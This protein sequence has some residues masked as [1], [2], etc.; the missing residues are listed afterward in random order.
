MK[1]YF[2]L[3]LSVV[4]MASI[5]LLFPFYAMFRLLTA[6]FTRLVGRLGL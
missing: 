5:L 3:I 4:L 1:D 2:L 6:A